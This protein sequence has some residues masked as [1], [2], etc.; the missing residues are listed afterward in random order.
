[1]QGEIFSPALFNLAPKDLPTLLQTIFD[2]HL[3]L[4]ADNITLWS[5]RE[6]PAHQ[7]EIIQRGLGTIQNHTRTIG[8]ECSLENSEFIVVI[9]RNT[10]DAEKTRESIRLVL[11]ENNILRQKC[12]KILGFYQP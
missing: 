6:S 3:G 12:I 9:N 5:D 11:E 10:K 4:Y 2:L 8:L 7:E 1:M